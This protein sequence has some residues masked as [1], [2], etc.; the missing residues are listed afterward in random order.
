MDDHREKT[1]TIGEDFSGVVQSVSPTMSIRRKSN[2]DIVPKRDITIADKTWRR[3]GSIGF[4]ISPSSKGGVRS[5]YY[6][7][8]S[9][10]HVTSNPS[11]GE[12]KHQSMHKLHQA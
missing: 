1:Q 9:L 11:L 2:K 5:M 10:A 7:R 8:V 12:D 3:E 4:D 6:D